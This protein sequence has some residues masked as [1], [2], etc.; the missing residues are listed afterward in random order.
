[1]A[2]RH[3]VL[4]GASDAPAA[5]LQRFSTAEDAFEALEGA[6]ALVIDLPF[7]NYPVLVAL[8]RKRTPPVHVLI[9]SDEPGATRR[10]LRRLGLVAEVLARPAD[11]SV[12]AWGEILRRFGLE[13]RAE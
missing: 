13:A 8:A 6:A 9:L 4:L 2:E 12:P 1:M 7:Q 5:G 10:E 11:A 3:I